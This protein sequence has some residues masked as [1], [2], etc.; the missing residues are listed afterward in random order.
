MKVKSE[1][2][3]LIHVRLLATPWTTVYQPPLSMGFSTQEYWSALEGIYSRLGD[4]GMDQR[5][6]RPSSGNQ[7]RC[8][9]SLIIGECKLKL[10]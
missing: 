4:R 6:R 1:S 9:P 5:L 10:Q 3:L 7:P 8:S 2:E